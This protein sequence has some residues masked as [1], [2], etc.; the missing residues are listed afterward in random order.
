MY[1]A[2]PEIEGFTLLEIMI[3]V[4]IVGMLAVIA[5]P[6]FVKVQWASRNARYAYD[7]RVASGAFEMYALEKGGFPS[8]CTPGIVPAGMEEYLQKIKWTEPTALGGEWDWDFRVFGVEAGVSVYRPD[9]GLPQLRSLD[10]I[11]DDG[12][13]ASGIARTRADGYI[14]IIEE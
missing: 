3:A 8:D 9:V 14:Y 4:A 6:S 5:V 12:V 10:K 11:I 2:C 13:L 1:L 7:I